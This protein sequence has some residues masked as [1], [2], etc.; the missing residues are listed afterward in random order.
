VR[1]S[2]SKPVFVG[3]YSPITN[4]TLLLLNREDTTR[5]KI[6][7]TIIFLQNEEV[8]FPS[9]PIFVPYFLGSKLSSVFLAVAFCVLQ[10]YWF[11]RM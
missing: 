5:M 2:A 7:T 9:T 4:H 8:H 3:S 1:V 10:K 11:L 6:R